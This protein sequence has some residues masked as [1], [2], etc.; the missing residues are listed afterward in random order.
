M[1]MN[2]GFD[3]FAPSS[4]PSLSDIDD[5]RLP[6]SPAIFIAHFN[7]LLKITLSLVYLAISAVFGMI[8]YTFYA[9]N[10]TFDMLLLVFFD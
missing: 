7:T 6:A 2:P 4:P 1:S 5:M 3:P 10:C 9:K 8:E